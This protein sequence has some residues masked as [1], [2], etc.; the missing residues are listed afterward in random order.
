LEA[1]EDRM[2]LNNRFVVPV[3]VAV[4]NATTFGTLQDALSTAGLAP[5]NTIQIEPGSTPGNVT[6]TSPPIANLTIAGD[7]AAP[8]SAIPQFTFSTVFTESS[9][10][11]GFT[12]QNVNVGIVNLGELLFNDNATVIG[13]VLT[14]LS[15][16]APDVITFGGTANILTNSTFASATAVTDGLVVIKTPAGGSANVISGDSF[17]N[18]SSATTAGLL[19]YAFGSAANVTDRVVGCTFTGSHVNIALNVGESVS[20]LTIEGNTITT[21]L[22]AGMDIVGVLPQNLRIVGNSIH[23]NS[24]GNGIEIGETGNGTLSSVIADNQVSTAGG[25]GLTIELSTGTT[26][27]TVEGNDFHNNKIGVDVGLFSTN[28]MVATIDLGGGTQGS[29]GQ[30]NFRSFSANASFGAAA[31][32]VEAGTGAQNSLSAQ[33]NLFASGVIPANVVFD[34]SSTKVLNVAGALTGNAALVA[35]LY[36]EILKRPADLSNP[37][38][39]GSWVTLLNSHALT[40]AQVASD[41]THSTEALD[42]VVNGLYLR[43]LHRAADLPGQAADVQ[44]LQNG[45]TIEQII[46]N[47]V[48]SREFANDIGS[49]AGFVESL[50]VGLLGRIASNAEVAG[51]LGLLPQLG[52]AQ[53]ANAILTSGEFRGD[54]V[55]QLYGAIPAPAVSVLSLLPPLLHRA[56]PPSASEVNGWVSLNLDALTL[57]TDFAS[58]TEFFLNG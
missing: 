27:L 19:S 11:A 57:E 17:V 1:L 16:T 10:Q 54:V 13:S 3:G 44:T 40:Q 58:G 14:D 32:E 20:G 49:D 36:N 4:D 15:S 26:A 39:A 34:A 52:R 45:G 5:G 37:S 6:A 12:L 25:T 43:F 35:T 46:I 51:W 48:T 22:F 50:Y 55:T 41:I 8:L 7:P 24:A 53:V 29:V 33:H 2:L 28:G 21:S 42:A 9:A 30:N 31:I 47:L 56:V 38:G 18:S 23:L